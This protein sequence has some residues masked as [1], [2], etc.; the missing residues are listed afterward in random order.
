MQAEAALAQP[1]QALCGN[2]GALLVGRH[3]HQCGQR[4]IDVPRAG[5]FTL[6]IEGL[7]EWRE[8][9]VLFV[10]VL[11]LMCVPGVVS[12]D[13]LAGRRIRHVNPVRAWLLCWGL[14]TLVVAFVLPPVDAVAV[15][16]DVSPAVAARLDARGLAVLEVVG[17]VFHALSLAL[18]GAFTLLVAPTAL[19][20]VL[21]PHEKG[22]V[23]YVVAALHVGAWSSIA[24]MGLSVWVGLAPEQSTSQ[25]I[26][27]GS[28]VCALP[29][30]EC[31]YVALTLWVGLGVPLLRAVG[32]AVVY[33]AVQWAIV[34][35]ALLLA[36]GVFV[37]VTM[38][39]V[40]R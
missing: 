21:G 25:I 27:V 7:D 39:L 29:A 14:S 38:T 23:A 32:A 11:L 16:Q 24:G 12:R 1:A 9:F 2:C 20:A 19:R 34:V 10:D 13:W 35:P 40:A 31:G 15:L 28:Y 3:C 30:V 5:L 8:R 26:A 33:E 6:V 22:A 37:G 18:L 17:E 4:H 36:A